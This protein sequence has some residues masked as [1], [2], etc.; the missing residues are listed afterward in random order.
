ML[1]H[2]SSRGQ[3]KF[4][5]NLESQNAPTIAQRSSSNV[6]AMTSEGDAKLEDGNIEEAESSL[7]ASV[8]LNNE[9]ARALLG[10]LEYQKGNVEAALQLFDGLDTSM[11]VPR[12][13]SCITEKGQQRRGRSRTE[14]SQS[15][16]LHAVGLLLEAI[17][18]KIK[19]LEK[20]GY[21]KEAAKE[22][23]SMLDAIEE[24]LPRGV[25]QAWGEFK[26]QETVNM[27]VEL[28]PELLKQAGLFS[29]AISAYRR[30]LLGFWNLGMDSSARI[31]KKL[32]ILLLYGGVEGSAET[33]STAV[34]EAFVPHNNIEEAILL[35][36]ILMHKSCS[37]S[38]AWDHTI[39]EHL[40]FAL[41]VCGQSIILAQKYEEVLPG[42]YNRL[43][44]WYN[45]SLCYSG[46]AENKVAVSLLRKCL[47]K[48]GKPDDVSC[49]LLATKLCAREDDL[50]SEGAEYGKRATEKA[51]DSWDYLKGRAY[52]LLGVVL[53]RSASKN[54]SDLV[55]LRLRKDAL[56]ALSKAAFYEKEDPEVAFDLGMEYAEQGNLKLA[57]SCAKR[58]MELYDGAS[59]KGWKLVALILSAQQ[60]Y[61]EALNTLLAASDEL[62]KWDQVDLLHTKAKLQ[63]VQGNPMDAIDTYR[64]LLALI[65]A[66]KKDSNIT[67]GNLKGREEKT[68]ELQVWQELAQVYVTLSQWS[69]A[70]FC[71]AR[72]QAIKVYSASTWHATGTIFEARGQLPQALAAYE[73]A[74]YIDT[75]HVESRVNMAVVLSKA[76]GKSSAV[77][78]WFLRD[79]LSTEPGNHIAWYNLGL[80]CEEEGEIREAADCYQAAVL[81][82]QSAPVERFTD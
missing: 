32:A 54:A 28:L 12:I 15:S 57:L 82:A 44:R 39:M 60:R 68:T 67:S 38:I 34:A 76:E 43:D 19:S 16:S 40:C 46:A 11:L 45:L 14:V 18:L 80:V 50:S 81:V 61:E 75:Q 65:Q 36:S 13:K 58:F 69:D 48:V 52:H 35:L 49:L 25:P 7:R 22:C 21:I 55:R 79:S 17:W 47:G 33:P 70:E 64:L 41:S 63:V 10:R 72:A 66:Q 30:G 29:E 31:Q 9:E 1:C 3:F 26:V 24:T 59:T 73:N 74:L 51:C 78:R 20:L 23:Q 42:T 8:S 77:A 5:E 27:V 62:D 53:G 2:C 6:S 37:N 71:L 4:E 56:N